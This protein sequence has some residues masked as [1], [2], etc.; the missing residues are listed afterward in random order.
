MTLLAKALGL[1]LTLR[2]R[3]AVVKNTLPPFLPL[4]V[5]VMYNCTCTINLKSPALAA[6]LN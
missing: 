2:T 1:Y 6:Y 5:I 4:S 3:P